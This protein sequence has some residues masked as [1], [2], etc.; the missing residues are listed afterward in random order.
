MRDNTENICC[1][2]MKADNLLPQEGDAPLF[3]SISVEDI[4]VTDDVVVKWEI[5]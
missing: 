4:E 5:K 3:P 2:A 1:A